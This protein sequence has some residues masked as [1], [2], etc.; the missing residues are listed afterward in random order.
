MVFIQTI[1]ASVPVGPLYGRHPLSSAADKKAPLNRAVRVSLAPQFGFVGSVINTIANAGPWA[2]ADMMRELFLT[3]FL[4]M[5]LPRTALEWKERGPQMAIETAIREFTGLVSLVFLS[6]WLG[7]AVGKVVN[8]TLPQ[9][10]FQNSLFPNNPRVDLLKHHIPAQELTYLANTFGKVLPKNT[11]KTVQEL[12]HA[13]YTH[14]FNTV[15]SNLVGSGFAEEIK[16]S[17][18]EHGFNLKVM[19]GRLKQ[20]DVVAQRLIEA[21]RAKLHDPKNTHAYEALLNELTGTIA[22]TNTMAKRLSNPE[23]LP[24]LLSK[25]IHIG[26]GPRGPLMSDRLTREFVGHLTTFW[27]HVMEPVLFKDPTQA[28]L[29]G[30]NKTLTPAFIQSA[31]QRLFGEATYVRP[32][33]LV[34]RL[35]SPG[36]KAGFFR[37][38]LH[39]KTWTTMVPMILAT[40]MSMTVAFV[41]NYLTRKRNQGKEFFPGMVGPDGKPIGLSQ[42]LQSLGKLTPVGAFQVFQRLRTPATSIVV[43]NPQHGVSASQPM[44]REVIA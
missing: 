20:P 38:L 9:L 43:V 30:T 11:G 7:L 15:Q 26:E 22:K 14:V 37:N 6:G 1:A 23:N 27:D 32:T 44:M 31:T 35:L 33:R 24:G 13:F 42:G 41:N 2:K 16:Q 40:F 29:L 8:R 21:A 12:Q 18:L 3:D 5:C 17:S 19:E 25:R 34:Q 28:H 4:G 10:S 39:A 36:P